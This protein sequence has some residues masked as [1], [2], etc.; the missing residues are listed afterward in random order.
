MKFRASWLCLSALV[1]TSFTGCLSGGGSGGSSSGGGGGSNSPTLSSISVS[2][3][4][5]SI[6]VNSTQQFTAT[7]HYSDGSTQ[8]LSSTATWTSSSTSVASVSNAGLATGAAAGTT[9]ITA[10][11]GSISGNASLTVTGTTGPTLTSISVTP[12]TVQIITG[13]TQQFTATGTYSDN[14][15]KDLTSSVTWTSSNTSIA[16]ISG[17]GLATGVTTG[18]ST[19]EATDGNIS[20]TATLMV[21]SSVLTS[22]TVTPA[23]P[24]IVAGHTQQFTATGHYSD[25]S[26][27]DITNT[28]AWNSSKT[29]VATI[30]N[31]GLATG[32]AA[33]TS[34]ITATLNSISGTANLTV[35]SPTLKSIAVTPASPQVAVGGTVQLTATGTYVDNSTQDITSTA[36]W[37][38]DN[39]SV[40]TVNS[41][42]TVTGVAAGSTTVHAASG[43]INGSVNLTVTPANLA[44]WW[45]FNEAGGAIAT[46]S[47]GNGYDANLYGGLTFTSGQTGGGIIAN[48]TTQVMKTPAIN[49]S[50]THALTLA[51]WVA[52]TWT[53]TTTKVLAE[54]GY[55]YSVATDGFV[56][57][58]DDTTDCGG[59]PAIY[60]GVK[61]DVGS[62]FNCYAPP[63]NGNWH[64]IAMVLDKSKS[65][66]S[67][68]QLYIDGSLKTVLSSKS[69]SAN[70]NNF[71]SEQLY[72][73]SQSGT[74]QFASGIVS[75]LRL[76]SRALSAG[77]ISQLYT[78]GSTTATVSSLSISPQNA[79]IAAGQPLQYDALGT[80]TDNS[81]RDLSTAV[82][83]TSSNTGT[84]TI[85]PGG[86][87]TGVAV[88]STN[89]QAAISPLSISTGL[90]VGTTA[91]VPGKLVQFSTGDDGVT[92][93]AHGVLGAPMTAGNML[94]VFS[95]WDN[96]SITATVSDS[97]GDTFTPI[98]GPINQGTQRFQIWY[99]KNIAGG[100]A[101]TIT[102]TYSA[103]TTKFSLVDVAEYS[104][105]DKNSP[106]G[107]FTHATGTGS[108]L[109][110]GS[111][112]VPS[113]N[114]QTIIGIFGDD[115][116]VSPFTS[117]TGFTQ[118]GF[119]ASTMYESKGAT[120][121]GSYNATATSQGSAN[122]IAFVMSFNNYTN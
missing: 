107:T 53:G 44:A 75:D 23:N 118:D 104:G 32:V 35:T 57:Y 90:T 12:S 73:F 61:G 26:T 54:L 119:D 10:T 96:Q 115:A 30:V 18:Y 64:H 1:L 37:S 13:T 87:A 8:N 98:T 38:S 45:R 91:T 41:A 103:Q 46:D 27:S 105:L 83:W 6:A 102:V 111:I 99:A 84:A 22:I 72:M 92:T 100:T 50:S 20:G 43:S 7:G 109:D 14:S 71:G 56:F 112:T 79:G 31:T 68:I 28:C 40:A 101:T 86:L 3:A 93:V 97:E 29:S 81:V 5:S 69:V 47:S 60:I 121:A 65:D 78:L 25:N 108:S 34:T 122:W 77:E 42:G 63:S 17:T 19:I 85:L 88:G 48:G 117:G 74:S 24:S 66:S 89:I 39:T 95:H 114:S 58:V 49:L 110:S 9:T 70:T 2:P 11:S 76:Y 82:T 21:A 106:L 62:T 55:D 36:T 67:A 113:A 15:T 4:T 33:G 59:S 52:R 94:L 116:Y 80:Y 51:G 120:S 16:T